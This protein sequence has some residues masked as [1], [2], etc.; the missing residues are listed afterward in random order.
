[1]ARWT[2]EEQTLIRQHYPSIGPDGLTDLLPERGRKAIVAQA[3]K[4]NVKMNLTLK[5]DAI[6]AGVIRAMK[7]KGIQVQSVPRAVMESTLS[8]VEKLALYGR[9]V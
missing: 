3:H 9:R 8:E 6:Q 7:E 4:L 2:K 5:N 1:M